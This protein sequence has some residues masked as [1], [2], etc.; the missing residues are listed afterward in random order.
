MLQNKRLKPN[1]VL[2]YLLLKAQTENISN[3]YI[4]LSLSYFNV[5]LILF[6]WQ[7]FKILRLLTR[8]II[9]FNIYMTDLNCRLR[10]I[11]Y[12]F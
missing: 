2:C 11:V 1:D 5:I 9:Y 4:Y 8:L 7:T 6:Y 12:Y 3:E 10:M